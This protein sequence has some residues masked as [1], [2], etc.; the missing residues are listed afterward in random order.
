MVA[1]ELHLLRHAEASDDNSQ[2]PGLSEKGESQARAIGCRLAGKKYGALLHSPRRRAAQTAKIL[3]ERLDGV[4]PTSSALL[5]DRTP[6]PSVARMADYPKPYR[7]LLA[8]TPPDERDLDGAH[9]S[10][11]F[12]ALLAEA[13]GLQEVGPLLLVTHAFVIAWFVRAALD[14]PVWRWIG[15]NSDNTG[16]T[17]LRINPDGMCTLKAF[18]DT[19]HLS[20]NPCPSQSYG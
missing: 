15:L 20:R 12:R 4:S 5:D 18:N 7:E 11:A 10:A 8:G 14:A 13:H 2:N 16:L 1:A 17:V 3:A 9:L 6:F 19:G